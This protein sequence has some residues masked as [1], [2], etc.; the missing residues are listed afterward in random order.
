MCP[1][2]PGGWEVRGGGRACPT[3]DMAGSAR[4]RDLTGKIG[5]QRSP[6]VWARFP[7]SLK[8]RGSSLGPRSLRRSVGSSRSVESEGPGVRCR[9]EGHA[10]LLHSLS[11]GVC[12]G[13]VWHIF[14]GLP[15]ASCPWL[16]AHARQNRGRLCVGGRTLVLSCGGC[17]QRDAEQRWRG[18]GLWK[19]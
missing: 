13:Y 15:Q 18:G 19:V 5:Q 3:W 1:P 10:P 7:L 2:P 17:A 4:S 11:G 8:P 6:F 14:I 16:C 12:A 9:V